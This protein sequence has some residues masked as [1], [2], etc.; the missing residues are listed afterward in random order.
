MRCVVGVDLGG[1]NVRAQALYEDGSP[2]G[3]RFENESLAQRGTERILDQVALTVKQ[4]VS[5][6][7]TPPLGVGMAIPGHIDDAAGVVRW[8][9]NFGETIDGVFHYWQNVPM[10]ADLEARTGTKITMANDANAAAM[11]EYM[12]GSGE[13]KANCLV[14]LT[15][16]TGIGGG[17]VLGPRSV[18]G[19]VTG[20]LL[21]VGGNMGGVELG[22][23][24]VLRGGLDC[25]AGTYGAVEAYCQR[26]AIIRRVTHKMRRGRQTV[27]FEYAEGDIAKV[28][29]KMLSQAAAEGDALSLEVWREFG[30][31]LGAGVANFI[32]IFAPDKLAIG[33]QVAKAHPYFMDALKNEAQNSAIPSLFGDCSIVIAQHMEDAGLLG[34]AALALQA[35][36]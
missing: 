25:N 18:Q 28:T 35:L 31:W 15:L 1:T 10:K 4:A 29:P 7:A 26:D 32:N 6:S 22:H 20:P 19:S 34:G 2:A 9:P 17:V 36:G 11:G 24:T 23:T 27:L 30:E 21:L 12:F 3:S 5:A 8:A 16:G 14:M 33:G 13:G